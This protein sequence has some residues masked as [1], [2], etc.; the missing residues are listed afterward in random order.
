MDFAFCFP[1]QGVKAK[2]GRT[3]AGG[4]GGVY[5]GNITPMIRVVSEN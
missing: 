1:W 2:R 3:G 5:G 4:V